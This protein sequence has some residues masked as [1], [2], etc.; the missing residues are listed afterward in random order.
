MS[1]VAPHLRRLHRFAL[2]AVVVLMSSAAWAEPYPSKT[3]RIIFPFSAGLAGDAVSRLIGQRLSEAVKQPVVVEPRPGAN[4]V[5]GSDVV[6]KAIPDGHTIIFSTINTQA[7]TPHLLGKLPYDP[8]KDFAPIIAM[9][10]TPY[11]LIVGNHLPAN[12]VKEFIA[13]AKSKP[14]KISIGYTTSTPQLT[15]E[16]FR[17]Q[18]GIDV[19]FVPYKT[20][21]TAYTDMIGGQL[22]AMFESAPSANIQVKAGRLKAIGVTSPK[23]VAIAPDLPTIAESGFPGFESDTTLAAFAPAGTPKEIIDTLYEHLARIVNIPEVRERMVQV[24]FDNIVIKSPKEL[25]E[26]VAREYAKWGKVVNDAKIAKGG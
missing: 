14:G 26:T 13:L 5:L 6:A 10:G 3:I 11:F 1:F 12:S 7:I 18:A 25:G 16:L 9:A 22:D 8:L 24:G 2:L 15:A 19:V 17:L 20:S 21:T 23:R 4:G